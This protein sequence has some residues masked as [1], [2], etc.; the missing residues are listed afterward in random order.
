MGVCYSGY[1]ERDSKKENNDR[2]EMAE[3]LRR[4]II[5]FDNKKSKINDK[6]KI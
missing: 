1:K 3:S 4:D 2:D 5:I 6:K